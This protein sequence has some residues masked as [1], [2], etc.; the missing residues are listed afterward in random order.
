MSNYLLTGLS[1]CSKIVSK[2][3]P[4]QLNLANILSVVSMEELND[5]AKLRMS[6]CNLKK[7]TVYDLIFQ[8]V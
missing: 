7:R 8:E 2:T 4:C 1:G 6:Q 5:A 3:N